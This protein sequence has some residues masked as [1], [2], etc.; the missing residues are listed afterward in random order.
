[1]R[2]MFIAAIA[3]VALIPGAANAQSR[4][5]VRHDQREINHDRREVNRDLRQ[6]RYH[7]AR[8]DRRELREDR[9]ERNQDWR[10]YRRSHRDAFRRP[11]YVGPR[12]WRYRPVAVG[13]RFQP[14]YY[15]RRYWVNDWSAYRLP[16]PNAMQRWVRYGNDVVLVNVRTGRVITVYNGFFW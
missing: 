2:T 3:A 8:E 14:V 6:G 1:M 5:E 15:G 9:R 7:E 4:Q 12:G 10:D 16:R 11:A 13:H